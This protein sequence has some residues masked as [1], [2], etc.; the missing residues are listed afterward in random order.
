MHF[1]VY[2]G[3]YSLHSHQQVSAVTAAIFSVMMLLQEYKVTNVGSCV[4]I[5]P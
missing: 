3:F 4:A 5:T 1:N 2:D